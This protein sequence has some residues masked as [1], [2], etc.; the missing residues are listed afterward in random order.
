MLAK[1]QLKYPESKLYTVPPAKE[2]PDTLWLTTET[3]EEFL[4]IPK[5]LLT[6]SEA[7]LLCT[8]FSEAAPLQSW[9][10]DT[11]D[12][13]SWH[14]F[15]FDGS[16]LE[17]D[18]PPKEQ[19]RI[20]QFSIREKVDNDLLKEA[21]RS[22]F[23]E[24]A[25]IVFTSSGT[26]AIV[27]KKTEWSLPDEELLSAA[28]VIEGDFF[29]SP[30]FFIGRFYSLNDQFHSSF[31]QEQNLF[32]FAEKNFAKGRVFTFPSTFPS[33]VLQHVPKQTKTSMFADILQL[34]AEDEELKKT[35]KTYLENQS[36]TSQTAKVLFMHRNS[37]QYR[38]DKFI[39]KIGIDIKTF[40]GALTVYLACLEFDEDD[41]MEE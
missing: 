13:R 19:F 14:D 22:I 28:A 2:D 1:L 23:A 11:A 4:A 30:A 26:G 12:S 25:I 38:I 16:S 6:Q 33:F 9:Q 29:V 32:S 27:E 8:L 34:F 20:I 24:Q 39:E 40:Q 3:N 36:N 35:I 15:L 7:E 31:K 37:V 21:F 5:H 18:I 41:N 10:N 17:L